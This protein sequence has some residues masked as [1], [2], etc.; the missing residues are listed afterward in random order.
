MRA[1]AC[2]ACSRRFEPRWPWESSSLLLLL[3][4]LLLINYSADTRGPLP[5]WGLRV[6]ETLG[7][8]SFL[9]ESD[10]NFTWDVSHWDSEVKKEKKEKTT[11]IVINSLCAL[12]VQ[13]LIQTGSWGL[14]RGFGKGEQTREQ[15]NLKGTR[16]VFRRSTK[17]R[18]S[19]GPGEC[20]RC[21][22]FL[23]CFACTEPRCYPLKNF[24][25]PS[26]WSD[27]MWF[28]FHIVSVADWWTCQISSLDTV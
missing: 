9:G 15:E 7:R 21:W 16:V 6:T 12:S 3:L 8:L 25:N 24:H 14:C 5:A 28:L 18:C 27:G 2:C 19:L 20:V 11:G 22:G 4:L 13:N 26:K 10:P 1:I 23:V 17:I